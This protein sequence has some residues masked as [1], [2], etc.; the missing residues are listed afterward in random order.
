MSLNLIQA[1]LINPF[2]FSRDRL[3]TDVAKVLRITEERI[4]NVVPYAYQLWVHI[5]GVGGKFV[6]YRRLGIWLDAAIAAIKRCTNLKSLQ[7]L[8]DIFLFESKRYKKQYEEQTI[9][10]LRDAWREK[11]IEL[12]IR[13][14]STAHQQE[15]QQWR[16]NWQGIVD[17]CNDREFLKYTM[18]EIH[19]QRQQFVDF[20]DVVASVE[21]ICFNRWNELTKIGVS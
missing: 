7:E 2:Q 11:Q 12:R 1:Q 14:I 10:A 8:G 19:R 4:E 20:P 15:A 17:R 18:S 6:S 5:K 13:E 9:Q 3:L 21:R 16:S